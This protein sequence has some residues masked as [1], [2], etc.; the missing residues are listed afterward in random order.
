HY[1]VQAGWRA[2][3]AIQGFGRTHRTNQ[4]SAPIFHLVTTNLQG[5]RRF[6]SSIARRLSQLGAL[7]KGERRTGES[8]LFGPKDNLES[9]EANTALSSLW[10]D[11]QDG[12]IEAIQPRDFEAQTGLRLENDNGNPTDPPQITQFLNRLLSLK[13]EMQNAVFGEFED[14]LNQT[15]DR[16]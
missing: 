1:L 11:M 6:I 8:G 13:F 9:R 2:D 7:T 14:R 12:K 10:R 5:Q 15:V 16:A 4:V 3:K